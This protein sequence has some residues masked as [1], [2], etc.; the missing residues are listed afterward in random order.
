MGGSVPP[1][2]WGH[3]KTPCPISAV[4]ASEKSTQPAHSKSHLSL[5]ASKA[6]GEGR[7][8]KCWKSVEWGCIKA[9]AKGMRKQN[10]VC[11]R[12]V[13]QRDQQRENESWGGSERGE[14]QKISR[15]ATQGEHN[16]DLST[17]VLAVRSHWVTQGV[18]IVQAKIRGKDKEQE[19]GK[20]K[21]SALLLF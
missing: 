21:G 14:R 6:E 20:P 13:N 3:R 19:W 5:Y 10:T 18:R 16:Q 1:S 4:L 15:K 8:E 12:C 9:E 17:S 2:I 11:W 7:N